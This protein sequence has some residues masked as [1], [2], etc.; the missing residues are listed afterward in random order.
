M[1][2]K[3]SREEKIKTGFL[4]RLTK[5]SLGDLGL[6]SVIPGKD[7]ER[8]AKQIT[9]AAALNKVFFDMIFSFLRVPLDGIFHSNL[10]R[11]ALFAV[12]VF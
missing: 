5:S 4:M 8:K 10:F 2:R 9:M 11:A 3:D 7:R 12:K 6:A 1:G